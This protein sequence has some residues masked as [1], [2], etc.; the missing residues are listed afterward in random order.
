MAFFF[1]TRR[2]KQ[3]EQL[4]VKTT[5]DVLFVKEKTYTKQEYE[6]MLIFITSNHLSYISNEFRSIYR[7]FFTR[8]FS[9]I[10]SIGV[11]I[12]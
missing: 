8:S 1:G 5:R 9:R 11:F 6:K 3:N 10:N 4:K 7:L 2:K 12:T